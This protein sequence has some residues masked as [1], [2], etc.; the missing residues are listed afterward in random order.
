[1][2]RITVT[3]S[4]DQVRMAGNLGTLRT[5][6]NKGG[7]DNPDYDPNRFTLTNLQNNVLAVIGEMGCLIYLGYGE[8]VLTNQNHDVWCGYVPKGQYH[9]L[10][11]PDIAGVIEVRTTRKRGNLLPIR[12]KDVNSKAILLHAYVDFDW[13]DDNKVKPTGEVEI[14]GW[15]NAV[16]DFKTGTIP[17]YSKNGDTRAVNRRSM[18]T[19]NLEALGL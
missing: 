3:L 4:E 7:R 1:M 2:S 12:T 16:E 5:N 9:L 11:Q 18:E 15:A 14:L 6:E 17:G 8:D 19:F 13:T 10:K